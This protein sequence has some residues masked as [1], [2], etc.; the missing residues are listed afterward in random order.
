MEEK[1][2]SKKITLNKENAK[3]ILDKGLAN[4]I[5]IYLG[6]IIKLMNDGVKLD[7]GAYILYPCCLNNYEIVKPKKD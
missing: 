3:Y 2:I 5:G 4:K 6:K 7:T 1:D